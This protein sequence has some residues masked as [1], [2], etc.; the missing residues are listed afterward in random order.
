MHRSRAGG[1]LDRIFAID[2]ER[3][4]IGGHAGEPSGLRL[5]LAAESQPRVMQAQSAERTDPY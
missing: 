5:G 3:I 4:A 2:V 1:Q